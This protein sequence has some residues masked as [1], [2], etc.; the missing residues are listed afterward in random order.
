MRSRHECVLQ[1]QRERKREREAGIRG[2]RW[3]DKD[4]K[5]GKGII[6]STTTHT[7]AQEEKKA[8]EVSEHL[9]NL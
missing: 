1:R 8:F 6:H 4:N 5:R 7:H 2:G 3:M 9:S